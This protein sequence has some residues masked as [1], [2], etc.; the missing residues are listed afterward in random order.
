[1]DL[2]ENILAGYAYHLNVMPLDCHMPDAGELVRAI[3]IPVPAS[4]DG[5]SR[6]PIMAFEDG[7]VRVT[8]VPVTHGRAPCP[9]L[10]F[11][12]S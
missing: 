11:R 5:A 7:L 4:I 2:V 1:M 9:R 10:P 3:D 8:T 12:Y 6:A